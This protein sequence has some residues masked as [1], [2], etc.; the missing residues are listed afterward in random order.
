MVFWY[1]YILLFL[2]APEQNI[3]RQLILISKVLQNL[4]NGVQFGDKEKHMTKLNGFLSSSRPQYEKFITKLCDN[5]ASFSTKVNIPDSS[6]EAGIAVVLSLLYTIAYNDPDKFEG[7]ELPQ[8]LHDSIVQTLPSSTKKSKRHKHRNK[9]E[10]DG[11]TPLISG[12]DN[13]NSNNNNNDDG[14]PSQDTQQ[15]QQALPPESDQQQAPPPQVQN[16]VDV[17]PPPPPQ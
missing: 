6:Y 5:T 11:A 10:A 9:K 2:E 16:L 17:P 13:N 14:A 8:E 12:D 3:R 4:A 15:Q 7:L 1:F